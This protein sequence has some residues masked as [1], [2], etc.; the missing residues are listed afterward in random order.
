MLK[1]LKLGRENMKIS[2]KFEKNM[3]AIMEKV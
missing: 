3:N 1:I 2:R